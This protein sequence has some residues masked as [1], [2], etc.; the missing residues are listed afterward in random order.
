M[1]KFVKAILSTGLSLGNG[2]VVTCPWHGATSDVQ[3]GGVLGPPAANGLSSYEVN[4]EGDDVRVGVH[5][6]SRARS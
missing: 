2:T 5:R 4:V 3:T 1:A 6:R